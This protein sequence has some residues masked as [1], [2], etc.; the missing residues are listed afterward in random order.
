MTT[1][2]E[3]LLAGER[4]L[5]PL[6]EAGGISGLGPLLIGIAVVALLIGMVFWR[7]GRGRD[8]PPRPSEQ[9]RRP[10]DPGHGGGPSGTG[11]SATPSGRPADREGPNS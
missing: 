8:R 9:P 5:E 3:F 4:T 10:V 7:S 11:G 2:E 6:A 1:T